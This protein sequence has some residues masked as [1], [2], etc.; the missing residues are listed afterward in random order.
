MKT[1]VKTL[2]AGAAAVAAVAFSS[3]ASAETIFQAHE[4]HKAELSNFFHNITGSITFGGPVYQLAPVYGTYGA[5]TYVAPAPVYAGPPAVA[6]AEPRYYGPR[7]Y[8]RGWEHRGYY[9][10]DDRHD[11]WRHGR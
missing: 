7:G 3:G 11:G 8:G 1:T 2:I 10:H 6:Y 9:R 5:P 4:R